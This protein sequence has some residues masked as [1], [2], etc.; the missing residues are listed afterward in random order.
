MSN[1]IWINASAGSGKTK[2]IIDR[3]LLLLLRGVKPSEILCVTFTKAAAL[4]MENRLF[5]KAQFFLTATE[6]EFE[7]YALQLGI[8]N[9]QESFIL[10]KKLHD[11]LMENPVNIKTLHSFAN[12][13]IDSYSYKYLLDKD[14]KII[15]DSEKEY[16][17][18]NNFQSLIK[19]EYGTK[20]FTDN[21]LRILSRYF[22]EDQLFEIINTSFRKHI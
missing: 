9:L 4:E 1:V 7:K 21:V 2:K 5:V 13:I 8:K 11:I 17:I 22:S 6:I 18:Q 15:T 19:K 14:F 3:I 20:S 16:L 10:S 12:T